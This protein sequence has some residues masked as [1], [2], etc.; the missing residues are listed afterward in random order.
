M[1]RFLIAGCQRSGTTLMRLLLGSH[2][3]ITCIDE[4]L[5]YEMLAGNQRREESRV[6]G[7][8]IPVWTEQLSEPVLRANE[9]A[10]LCGF[11]DVRNFYSGEKIVFLLRNPLDT[12]CSMMKL[13][14]LHSSW[15]ERVCLPVLERK[16]SESEFVEAFQDDILAATNAADRL[17][18][19]GA[20]YW[21]CKTGALLRYMKSGLPVHP[22]IYEQLVTT[23]AT[24]MREVLGFLGVEW[25]ESVLQHHRRS[26]SQIVGGKAMGGTDPSRSVDGESVGQWKR[27]LTRE[28][29]EIVRRISDPLVAELAALPEV[30]R[31]G[32]PFPWRANPS[33]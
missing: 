21:K 8:K 17:A 1:N 9:L 32:I 19:S 28:Q 2:S 25:Q 31:P 12:V 3:E 14:L 29:I 30:P 33:P 11:R 16:L 20:L 5:S 10:W 13:K 6:M 24:V 15:L 27:S 18:A 23:T 4:V 22:V 26:H 7:F